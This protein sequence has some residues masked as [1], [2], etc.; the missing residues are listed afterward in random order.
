VS[1][2]PNQLV[3][4]R[5]LVVTDLPEVLAIERAAYDYPWSEGIFRDC[6]RVGYRC[7]VANDLAGN[8]L[9]YALL[10]VVASE[11]HILNL[12]VGPLHR[13][14]GIASLLLEHTMREARWAGA[15]T[16]LLEVRPSNKAALKLYRGA[17]FE[18]I[19]VR[20]RY[21]P[22]ANGREDALLYARALI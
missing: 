8:V 16:L 9:G 22:A 1:A 20:K 2:E 6:L 10:S 4:V 12:C 21:Y 13:R 7:Y 3:R 11:G 18:R 5:D 15:D 19:G 17:G 14:R